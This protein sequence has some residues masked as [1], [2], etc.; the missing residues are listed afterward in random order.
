MKSKTEALCHVRFLVLVEAEAD[1]LEFLKAG[2]APASQS[3][4]RFEQWSTEIRR[5]VLL[6]Q[7]QFACRGRRA[8]HEL[9]PSP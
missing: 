2:P 9:G 6:V 7:G 4:C 5:V 1:A 3:P 8:P